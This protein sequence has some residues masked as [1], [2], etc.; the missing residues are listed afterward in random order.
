MRNATW[1]F[2]LD[3]EPPDGC[4]YEEVFEFW[5]LAKDEASLTA[6]GLTQAVLWH[7]YGALVLRWWVQAKPGTRPS[8]WW[9][10][11]APEPRLRLSGIGSPDS[12]RDM[13]F[14]VPTVWG[15][16]GRGDVHGPRELCY[17]VDDP[18]LYESEAT[19]LRRHE[20]LLPSERRQLT[21]ADYAPVRITDILWP[22]TAVEA[23]GHEN[24]VASTGVG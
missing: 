10:F 1:S 23:V 18:P 14:G 16:P 11:R 6:L 3:Q 13:K 7:E 9:K 12:L 4:A 19:F 21:Q 24:R 2:L 22:E 5:M 20:L 17:D 8:L 15:R